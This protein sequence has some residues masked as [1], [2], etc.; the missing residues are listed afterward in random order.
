MT[1]YYQADGITL[2]HGDMREILPLLQT[3]FDA[4]VTDPPYN[5]TNLQWDIW[6]DGWPDL[7]TALTSSLWCFGSFRMFWD[8]RDQFNAWKLSQD[9]IWEKHNGSGMHADR[10][11]RIHE[12]AIHLYRGEW[13]AIHKNP[14]VITVEEQRKRTSLVRGKKPE[15]WKGIEGG[16]GYSYDGKRVMGSIIYA[17]SCHGHAVN[18]TQKPEAIVAPLLQ[19][20]V[21]PRGTVIDPFA[22]SGTTLVEARRQGFTAVGIEKRREQCEYIVARLSQRELFPLPAH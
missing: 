10:F 5:E 20:A 14:P 3:T 1:P 21:P 19:Y 8:R 6:P 22:G 15:H 12:L 16:S 4:C 11:R 7:V 18:E 13:S 9:I 17:R 2:Y